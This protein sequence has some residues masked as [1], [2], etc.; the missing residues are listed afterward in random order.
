MRKF[1]TLI[2]ALLFFFLFIGNAI[3]A[4][5]SVLVNF[6][7]NNCDASSLPWFSLIKQPLTAA[8]TLLANCN[9]AA[10]T[11]SFYSVFIAYNPKDNKIY[12]ADN[13]DGVQ[14][15]IWRLDIGLPLNIACPI[16]IPVA[17][18]YSYTYISNN[19]E[20]DNNGDLWSLSNFNSSTG[21]C[22]LEKFD[23]N[24]GQVIS[25]R[26]IQFPLSNIPTTIQSGDIGILPN[27]RMFATLG[28]SPSRLYE[29][30]NYNGT[31]NATAN[32]LQTLPLDCYGIAYINGILE[33]TGSD[34]G[35]SCYYYD[36]NIATGVL[37]TQKAF[38]NGKLPID[39]TSFTPAVGCTKRLLNAVK[40]NNNTADLTYE[41][42]GINYGNVV[43][44]NVNITDDLAAAFGVGNVSNVSVSFVSGSNAAN[45]LLNTGYNGTTVKSILAPN[46]N[47]PN[48]VLNSR[49]Y[50]FKINIQ[51]RVTNLNTTITYNN[52]AIAKGDIGSGSTA[53][54]VAVADSSNNGDTTVMD[55]NKNGNAGD[56]G[57]NIPTPFLFSSLPV[58]FINVSG[59]LTNNTTATIAWKVAVPTINATKFEVEYSADGRNWI[60]LSQINISNPSQA[61]YQ[62]PHSNIPY[63]NLYYRIKETDN[64]GTYVYSKIVLL[65]NKPG[66]N[67]YIIFPNPAADIVSISATA[68]FIGTTNIE[69]YDAIGRKLL[70]KKMTSSTAEITTTQMPTGTYLLRIINGDEIQ[71]QKLVIKH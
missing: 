1:S 56:V 10:Q 25:T 42:Y 30:V 52:S 4:Q 11:A 23:V 44:N 32:F 69:L 59:S 57:E 43:L 9:V 51:C 62:F 33:L 63:G 40:I 19:F 71:T 20:F 66:K 53:S 54:L 3:Y 27:G 28:S 17:P 6:G 41:V 8:P 37:G 14:T 65:H 2:V 35:G 24:T 70:D 45:L 22:N 15:K 46:Q 61:N 64:D 21:Q 50:F 58:H 68:T 48:K 38:Q 13:R 18:T 47:L 5:N 34:F 7:G 29:I 36:Y 16:S 49:D 12:L 67:S 60:A 39:N 55:P 26:V 31:A